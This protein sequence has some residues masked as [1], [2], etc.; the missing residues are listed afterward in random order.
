MEK[1][2]VQ[3]QQLLFL[4]L[5][6]TKIILTKILFWNEFWNEQYCRIWWAIKPWSYDWNSVPNYLLPRTYVGWDFYSIYNEL[7]IILE[8][9]LGINSDIRVIQIMLIFMHSFC[10]RAGMKHWTNVAYFYILNVLQ[11]LTT[12]HKT[13]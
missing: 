6:A 13:S 12:K 3:K 2:D 8:I 4:Y 5:L 9:M 1:V 7:A 10:L 11:V